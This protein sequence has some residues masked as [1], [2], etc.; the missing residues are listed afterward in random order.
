M[1]LVNKDSE[2]SAPV[3]VPVPPPKEKTLCA[4]ATEAQQPKSSPVPLVRSPAPKKLILESP[5][6]SLSSLIESIILA[7]VGNRLSGGAQDGC[8]TVAL[9]RFILY[10]TMRR[11]ASGLL[12]SFTSLCCHRDSLF[13]ILRVFQ[14]P[15]IGRLLFLL[16]LAV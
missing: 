13:G 16:L 9:S 4:A 15:G 12:Q 6:V 5:Q 3:A 2:L 7:V 11:W 1:L 14:P 8:G 10:D